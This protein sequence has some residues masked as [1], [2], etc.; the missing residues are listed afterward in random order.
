MT[1]STTD[2]REWARQQ[3]LDVGGKGRIPQSVRDQYDAEH[4]GQLLPPEDDD[5][6]P[7]PAGEAGDYDETITVT[8]VHP[9]GSIPD[10]AGD[11]EPPPEPAAG[12]PER[13]AGERKPRSAGKSRPRAGRSFR[14]R[15][16]GGGKAKTA[17]PKTRHP[18]V[19]LKGFAEDMFLDLAW[20]FQGLPPMEKILYLQAPLA[21]SVVEDTFKDTL[22]DKVLQPA[23]RFDRQFKALEALTAPAWVGLII[24]RGR[25]DEAGE[26]SPQTKLMFSGLRHS[27]LS[28]SRL[29]DTDFEQLKTK[30]EELRTASG[31]IDAMIAWLFEM[32]A[33]PE[34]AAAAHTANGH[35]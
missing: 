30:S 29:A 8:A 22:A 12:G 21:G 25:R 23:A 11:G 28:M 10:P 2:V 9:P 7:D 3:G 15:V 5:T 17:R 33:A 24:A 18:R 27:L 1:A 31:Q 16:W 26:Y 6:G 34:P 20:T 32:P 19:S 14:E 13:P 35:G 4:P